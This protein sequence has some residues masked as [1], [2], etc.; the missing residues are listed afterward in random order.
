MAIIDT[1]NLTNSSMIL[2]SRLDKNMS[3]KNHYLNDLQAKR[4]QDWEFRYNVVGIEE[5][6]E[7]QIRYSDLLPVYSPIDVVVRS[8]KDENG[9]DLGTDWVQMSF[10]DLKYKN[11]IG[12]RYRFSLD[13]PD[14]SLMSE[15][16]KYYDTSV[17]MTI[18]DSP[19]KAGSSCLARRCNAS[20]AILGSPTGKPENTNEVRYEPVVVDS[21]LKYMQLYYNQTLVV[22]QSEL[23]LTAQMNYFSNC[24]KINDRIILGPIDTNEI[25]NNSLYKVKAVIKC[26][27]TKTFVK[28]GDNGIKD[29]PMVVFALDKDTVADE[30]DLAKRIPKNAPVYLIPEK[31]QNESNEYQIVLDPSDTKIIL[32]DSRECKTYL[33]LKGN[34]I[35]T[36]FEYQTVLNGIKEENWKNYY[37]FTKINENSFVIKNLKACNRGTLDVIASCKD[38]NDSNITLTETFRFRLGGFY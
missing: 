36:E 28:E 9:K 1:T 15:E 34:R 11:E 27:S 7:K 13:F 26:A 20:I 14:M 18:N 23:Y 25:Q 12:K 16:D 4:D 5:E 31:E 32:G 19:L 10:K 37:I 3:I 6:K 21:E 22:P 38:P 17:W 30:D 33:S 2:K 29:I 8:V 24:I 35:D